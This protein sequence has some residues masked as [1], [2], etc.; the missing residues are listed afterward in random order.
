M[1]SQTEPTIIDHFIDFLTT[2]EYM[3]LWYAVFWVSAWGFTTEVAMFLIDFFRLTK[4][5][6]KKLKKR[7]TGD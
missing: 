6:G 1:S 4:A 7:G 2:Q 3:R 5:R